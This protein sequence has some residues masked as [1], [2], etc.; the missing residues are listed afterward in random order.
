MSSAVREKLQELEKEIEKFR[1]E[2]ATLHKLRE[3]REKVRN[4]Y[5]VN[6]LGRLR[7]RE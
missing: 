5:L 3:E 7:E 4:S 2:N 1:E 6:G